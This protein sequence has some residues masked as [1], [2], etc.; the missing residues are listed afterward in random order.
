[1]SSWTYEF[2]APYIHTYIHLPIRLYV[3]VDVVFGTSAALE[4]TCLINYTLSYPYPLW[5]RVIQPLWP[6]IHLM[7]LNKGNLPTTFSYNERLTILSI[8]SLAD[9]MNSICL[10]YFKNK[11]NFP[12]IHFSRIPQ[13]QSFSHGHSKHIHANF[14]APQHALDYTWEISFYPFV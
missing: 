10:K 11:L 9:F 6:V 4:G 3:S 5:N 12:H 8:S 2:Y 13:R 1:M 14:I 7:V